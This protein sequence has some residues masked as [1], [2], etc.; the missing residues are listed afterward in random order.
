MVSDFGMWLIA[1]GI[2][3]CLNPCCNGIWSRT[4]AKLKSIVQINGLNPCCNGIWSRT[5]RYF[6]LNNGNIVG[7]NPCCNG[8]WSRTYDD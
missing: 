7:L 8:I 5:M 2:G 4:K 1:K 6:N 3:M